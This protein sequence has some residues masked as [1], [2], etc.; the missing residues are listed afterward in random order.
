E[1]LVDR[2]GVAGARPDLQRR[3]H[4]L[5]CPASGAAA[6]RNPLRTSQTG[7]PPGHR[8][9][10]RHA[11]EQYLADGVHLRLE[12]DLPRRGGHA[13]ARRGALAGA[14][15]RGGQAGPDGTRL[16]ALPAP[17]RLTGRRYTAERTASGA[18]PFW[19]TTRQAGR[20][21]VTVVP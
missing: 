6:D 19:S 3:A 5:S 1:G 18:C 17:A 4:R 2:R 13:R 12:R 15:D 16:P 11:D 7:R 21:I 8:Q 20:W 14:G 10:A 9:H